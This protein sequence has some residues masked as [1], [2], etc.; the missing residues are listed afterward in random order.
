MI[1]NNRYPMLGEPRRKSHTARYVLLMLLAGAA[2]SGIWWWK[3]RV[4]RGEQR[5]AT[6]PVSAAQAPPAAA[7]ASPSPA[8]TAPTAE[9]I[10]RKSGVRFISPVLESSRPR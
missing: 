2:A 10:L 1:R 7:P 9:E 6:A 8:R 5:L 4:L 3:H